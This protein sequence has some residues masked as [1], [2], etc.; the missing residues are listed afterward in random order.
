MRVL[1]WAVCTAVAV[2]L[3]NSA[4]VPVS[5]KDDKVVDNVEKGFCR[6]NSKVVANIILKFVFI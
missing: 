6:T 4:T 2:S 3:G 1:L 5:R